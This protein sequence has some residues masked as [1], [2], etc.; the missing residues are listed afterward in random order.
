VDDEDQQHEA[1]RAALREAV[2]YSFPTDDI[3]Q[4]LDEIEQGY[5]SS[6]HDRP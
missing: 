1:K 5:L 6:N 4:M 2:Q 3:H